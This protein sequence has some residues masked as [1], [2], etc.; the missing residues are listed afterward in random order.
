MDTE[1]IAALDLFIQGLRDMNK[2]MVLIKKSN[3]SIDPFVKT[4]GK[5]LCH[6]AIESAETREGAKKMLE[7]LLVD[8]FVDSWEHIRSE[9]E[10]K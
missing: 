9:K 1:I 2:A 7:D 4:I 3:K 10:T 6:M 5:F 8:S